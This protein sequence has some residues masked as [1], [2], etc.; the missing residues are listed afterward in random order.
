[1][2]IQDLSAARGENLSLA[3]RQKRD[4]VLEIKRALQGRRDRALAPGLSSSGVLR[5]S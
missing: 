5:R 4:A 2:S 3:D 1:M